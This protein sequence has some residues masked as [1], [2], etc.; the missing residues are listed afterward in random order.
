M[1]D[2]SCIADIGRKRDGAATRIENL[3]SNTPA[4]LSIAVENSYRSPIGR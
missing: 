3:S 1:F 2:C 4:G